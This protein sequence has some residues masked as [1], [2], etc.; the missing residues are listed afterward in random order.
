LDKA[1]NAHLVGDRTRA[2]VLITGANIQ[3]IREWTDSIWGRHDANILRV[4][5]VQNSL[6]RLALAKRP[7][8]RHPNRVLQQRLIARDGYHCRF[9]GIPVIDRRI[10]ALLRAEYPEALCWGPKNKDQHAAFQCMW[11]QFDHLVPNGRGGE[12]TFDNLA[13]TCAPCNFGRMER[14]LE[15][16][17]VTVPPPAEPSQSGWDGLTRLVSA[18]PR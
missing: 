8:P 5:Q 10:R 3:A 4:R 6:P 15:E 13:I 17:G 16:V 7:K 2:A 1:A 12:S 14:T 18:D 11:L 9:C